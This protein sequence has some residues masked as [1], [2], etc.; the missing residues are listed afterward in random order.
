[1]LNLLPHSLQRK[2]CLP[3]DSKLLFRNLCGNNSS[4]VSSFKSRIHIEPLAALLAKEILF[5]LW[6]KATLQKFLRE[7]L[8][9]VSSLEF[10][11][12]LL[13]HSLQRKSCLLFDS[14]LLFKNLCGKNSSLVSSFKFRIY[15]EPFAA[16][17]AKEILFALWFKATLQKSLWLNSSLVNSFKF[18]IDIEPLA[19]LLAKEILLALCKATLQ[20][21]L[22]QQFKSCE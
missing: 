1:M 7:K 13:P 15:I 11:L 17:L 12:N 3:F 22:W 9:V 5:A 2:S 4:L 19:A 14:K 18:R 21:S 6:F 20:K 10:I 8:W 16:L